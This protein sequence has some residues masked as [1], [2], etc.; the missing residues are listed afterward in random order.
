MTYGTTRTRNIGRGAKVVVVLSIIFFS[1]SAFTQT[2]G[3]GSDPRT[4]SMGGA[5]AATGTG[6]TSLNNNPSGMAQVRQYAGN[7]GYNYLMGSEIHEGIL[8]LTDSLLNPN[9]AMGMSYTYQRYSA[10]GSGDTS[11]GHLYRGALSLFDRK[12][13]VTYA[14]GAS[15]HYSDTGTLYSGESLLNF[16]A[17]VLLVLQDKFRF[18]AFA[19]NILD[20]VNSGQARIVQG[21]AAFVFGR[22]L[23]E[24]NI[25]T[26]FDSNPDETTLSH[27]VGVEVLA[28]GT[29]PIRVGY[30]RDGILGTHIIAGGLGYNTTTT[31]FEFSYAQELRDGG[32]SWI[33]GC[34]KWFPN[35]PGR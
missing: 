4:L 35:I 19:R 28:S 16:D 1:Q 9:M 20:N 3:F 26:D 6:W 34:L 27:A 12:P 29:I 15:I 2:F 18:G 17:G 13:A 11:T 14:I 30:R 7:A 21:G 10:A 33:M 22:A 31:G 32:N 23:L 8:S 24:Y 25:I 5:V